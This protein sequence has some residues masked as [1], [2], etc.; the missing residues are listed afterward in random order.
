V[1]LH[2]G[3]ATLTAEKPDRPEVPQAAADLSAGLSPETGRNK[4]IRESLAGRSA[5]FMPE[6]KKTGL[7]RYKDSEISPA[8]T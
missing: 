4:C 2:Q 8:L 6:K 5:F 7:A 3:A 1:N